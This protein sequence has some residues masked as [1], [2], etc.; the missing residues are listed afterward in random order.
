M[1]SN[2]QFRFCPLLC[3]LTAGKWG[4]CIF[5]WA[6]STANTEWKLSASPHSGKSWEETTE[7]QGKG[8]TEIQ[9]AKAWHLSSLRDC[10]P[11]IFAPN[12]VLCSI[13]SEE[14]KLSSSSMQLV[15]GDTMKRLHWETW[16]QLQL[17]INSGSWPCGESESYRP[18][19]QKN[20]YSKA[21]CQVQDP[22]WDP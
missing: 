4:E 7:C 16:L 8:S 6:E 9:V 18:S 3:D 10:L 22:S 5:F 1:K 20:A 19:P 12:P 13:I 14:N 11:I 2:P 17:L 21:Y 15:S